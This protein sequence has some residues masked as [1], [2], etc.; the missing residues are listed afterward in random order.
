[1][2]DD[3]TPDTPCMIAYDTWKKS[4][5]KLLNYNRIVYTARLER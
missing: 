2:G 3:A 1:M 5:K 4:A